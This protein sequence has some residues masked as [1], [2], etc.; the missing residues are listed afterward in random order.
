MDATSSSQT[1]GPD[2]TL[3]TN[4]PVDVDPVTRPDV[5]AEAIHAEPDPPVDPAPAPVERTPP[6]EPHTQPQ[7]D[8]PPPPLRRS[9]RHSR[10]KNP[11]YKT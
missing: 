3:D 7:Q 5:P 10:N 11:Q 9:T 4:A 1:D 8:T 6:A 2:S